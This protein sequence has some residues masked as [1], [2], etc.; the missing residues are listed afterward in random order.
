V[1]RNSFPQANLRVKKFVKGQVNL[2]KAAKEKLVKVLMLTQ[3]PADGEALSAIR[4][5]NALLQK[6]NMTWD[7]IIGLAQPT[8]PSEIPRPED[9]PENEVAKMVAVVLHAK[10]RVYASKTRI[11]YVTNLWANYVKTNTITV[12]EYHTLRQIYNV[13]L[14]RSK[15]DLDW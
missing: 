14:M 9:Y 15:M 1:Y 8:R 12:T 4:I 6:H 11:T 5:A 13:V 2:D 7:Q 10:L 3:S